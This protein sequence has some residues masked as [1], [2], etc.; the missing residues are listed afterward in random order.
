MEPTR[1]QLLQSFAFATAGA[2]L[3]IHKFS[4][5]DMSLPRTRP[6]DVGIDPA[7][8]AA[9]IDEVN[10]KVGGLHGMMLLR[11]GKVAAEAWWHPYKPKRPH[12][13]YS[14]SKSF[15]STAVGLAVTEGRLSVNDKVVSFFP[16]KLPAQMSEHLAEMR[17][18]D[19][20]TMNSGHQ[21]E[22]TRNS[23]DWV[24]EFLAAPVEHK[25]GTHF[26]YNT[27]ATHVCSAIVQKLTGQRILTY[28]GPRLF[29][30]LGIHNPTWE[31][32]PAGVDFG[33]SGL[34]I[35]TEDMAKFGQLYL[36]KGKWDGKQLIPAEW[37]AEA[38]ALQVPNGDSQQPNDWSQ[39]YGYQ[40]WR[41]RHGFYRGDGAF[42]QY[43]IVMDDLDAVL[44]INSGVGDMGAVM[45]ATWT[46]LLPALRAGSSS[47]TDIQAKLQNQEVP[48]PKGR[49]TSPVA[50]QVSGRTF[51]LDP[52]AEGITTMRFTLDGDRCVVTTN[53]SA[54]EYGFDRWIEG[55]MPNDVAPRA[56]ASR[57][58]WTG[59]NRLTV[60]TCFVE[61]P[62]EWT[63]TYLF[64]G[65]NLLVQDRKMNVSFGP[66]ARPNLTGRAS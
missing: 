41:C 39:G 44:A 65:D 26:L 31:Q 19:L 40:F 13:L 57:A 11:H 61:A 1:R 52:N 29:E 50:N 15:T 64:D 2:A 18:K 3:P 49:A 16:D 42:G 28:L 30:P 54:L 53:Q 32:S 48:Y 6:E 5:P 38:T 60:K 46:H 12:M 14:L 43:C 8:I 4:V 25:P 63:E 37:I 9:F 20:L 21:S 10:Q 58:A 36:Q 22:P 27:S 45:N 56:I 23:N 51:R 17:V 47:S 35:R 59:D 24:K 62:Y 7:G 66:G 34:N 55:A 33:G